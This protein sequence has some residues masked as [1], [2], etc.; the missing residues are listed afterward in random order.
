M[1]DF[2][3]VGEAMSYIQKNATCNLAAFLVSLGN[4]IVATL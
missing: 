4:G 2:I 3:D 1:N